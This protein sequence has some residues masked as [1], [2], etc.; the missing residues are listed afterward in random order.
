MGS[1]RVGHDWATKQQHPYFAKLKIG[2]TEKV[3]SQNQKANQWQRQEKTPS[4]ILQNLSS[5][6]TQPVC[7]C[8]PAI[9]I[10]QWANQIQWNMV[11]LQCGKLSLFTNSQGVSLWKASTCQLWWTQEWS[12]EYI[13]PVECECPFNGEV[14]KQYRFCLNPWLCCSEKQCSRWWLSH[15]PGPWVRI[16]LWYK[17]LELHIQPFINKLCEK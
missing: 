8:S 10:A 5:Y 4:G 16:L 15:Q 3:I 12:Y 7:S 6:S 13:W 9:I 2:C 11:K 17:G 1:Q 14:L